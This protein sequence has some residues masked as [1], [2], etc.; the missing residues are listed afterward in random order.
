MASIGD[1]FTCWL[2][3]R[4]LKRHFLERGLTKIFT[5]YKF[6]NVL[7][8]TIAFFFKMFKIWCRFQIFNKKFRNK[9]SFFRYFHF[10][11]ELQIL[12][13]L[14]RILAIGSHCVKKHTLDYNLTLGEIFSKS[15]SLKFMKE[16]DKI[17]LMGISQ[18]FGT[19]SYVDCLSVFRNCVSYRVV[20]RSFSQSVFSE[21]Q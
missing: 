2:S 18:V 16:H 3:K 7:A 9:F 14:Q 15:T 13:I 8:M 21:T 20:W 4:L 6:G 5:V 12:P 1:G 11:W 10:N 17:T 19:L